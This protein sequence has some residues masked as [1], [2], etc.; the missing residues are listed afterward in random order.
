MPFNRRDWLLVPR[1]TCS[2]LW[3][4]LLT[5]WPISE[6]PN[7][8]LSRITSTC[9]QIVDWSNFSIEYLFQLITLTSVS[10]ATIEIWALF[11]VRASQILIVLSA[12]QLQNTLDCEGDHS[13][14]SMEDV[15]PLKN[16]DCDLN[17]DS[18]F[19][20]NSMRPLASP[21]S[22][23]PGCKLDQHKPYPSTVPCLEIVNIGGGF[24]GGTSPGVSKDSSCTLTSWIW[25][26]PVSDELAI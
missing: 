3:R 12:E 25:I 18:V 15:W 6:I 22:K 10:W 21:V 7:I 2:R 1:E 20:V 5:I 11:L 26:L 8:E 19:S 24:R 14:S 23:F 13:I 9:Q 17:P 16:S 4:L